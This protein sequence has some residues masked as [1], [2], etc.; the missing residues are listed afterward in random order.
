MLEPFEKIA[1]LPREV[2]LAAWTIPLKKGDSFSLLGKE[3]LVSVSGEKLLRLKADDGV[4]YSFRRVGNYF[5]TE[6]KEANL[7]RDIE[8]Q[9][10]VD[11]INRNNL[12]HQPSDV[13]R[14]TQRAIERMK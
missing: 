5:L 7:I 8:G 2:M 3:Y 11:L 13:F 12:F 1:A 14:L 9:I 6:G 4:T 10:T